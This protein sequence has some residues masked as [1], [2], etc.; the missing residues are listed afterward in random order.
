MFYYLRDM[1]P[2]ELLLLRCFDSSLGRSACR[3]ISLDTD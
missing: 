2:D 3:F 1:M